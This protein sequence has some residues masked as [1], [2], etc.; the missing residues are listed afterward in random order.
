MPEMSDGSDEEAGD[1]L[2]TT[3]GTTSTT[4]ADR[5]PAS[6]KRAEAAAPP[7]GGDFALLSEVNDRLPLG[8]SARLADDGAIRYIDR[9]TGRVQAHR[10][11]PPTDTPESERRRPFFDMSGASSPAP[12]TLDL[13]RR[14]SDPYDDTSDLEPDSTMRAARAS[15]SSVTTGTT[16]EDNRRKLKELEETL[17]SAELDGIP[18][19]AL[20]VRTAVKALKIAFERFVREEDLD[21]TLF[22]E[23]DAA[24]L[25]ELDGVLA[26]ARALVYASGVLGTSTASATP[27]SDSLKRSH[28]KVQ[29]AVTG[30][31]GAVELFRH[32]AANDVANKEERRVVGAAEDVERT[33]VAFGLEAERGR[34]AASAATFGGG[35]SSS[36][37][38]PTT[39]AGERR[40][41]RLEA[42]LD[43]AG[44]ALPLGGRG[45]FSSELD[46]DVITRPFGLD[47][48]DE[49][50]QEL[51]QEALRQID[52]YAEKGDAAGSDSFASADALCDA[53]QAVLAH[54]RSFD[55]ALAIDLDGEEPH[56]ASSPTYAKLVG[57]ANEILRQFELALDAFTCSLGDLACVLGSSAE[58]EA[59]V[60]AALRRHLPN[61]VKAFMALN[62]VSLAQTH[63][64]RIGGVKGRLGARRP[65]STSSAG[66]AGGSG[67]VDRSTSRLS[68]NS[69]RSKGSIGSRRSQLLS[70]RS[71]RRAA[72]GLD[73][74]VGDDKPTEEDEEIRDQFSYADFASSA[75]SVNGGRAR[76][77][78]LSAMSTVSSSS[79]LP[80]ESGYGIDS[81]LSGVSSKSNFDALNAL[82][83][84]RESAD[85]RASARTRPRQ[86]L[87][88]TL[89]LLVLASDDGRQPRFGQSVQAPRRQQ[90]QCCRSPAGRHAL[91]P[92]ERRQ[93]GR[94]CDGRRPVRRRRARDQGRVDR[95]AR[96]APDAAPV[97]I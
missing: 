62:T 20:K 96:H 82:R 34:A 69:A 83:G 74:E 26:A 30:L 13:S 24:V 79:S 21:E 38:S 75:Q 33:V 48:E 19:L 97:R 86:S 9:S 71:G 10:P 70:L 47:A 52:R 77:G 90:R 6:P 44:V 61:S 2:T 15:V 81:R 43:S 23:A 22:A 91:V 12:T 7:G 49:R 66:G 84:R 89:C 56:P 16:R 14:A 63:A 78:S 37:G 28:A 94:D 76:Q 65:V 55:I 64:C 36:D 59:P 27:P 51:E 54:L 80:W 87:E 40:P 57:S 67:T 72:R 53:V 1:G 4:F 18:V 17:A 3:L 88:L 42:W 45:G 73:E 29:R 68:I 93:R 32:A 95:G 25:V 50:L 11:T 31:I 60:L 58:A 46:R 35:G 5:R 8:W 85:S 92:R 41:R 39:A